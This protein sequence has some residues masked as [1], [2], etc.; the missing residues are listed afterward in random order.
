[1]ARFTRRMTAEA[2]K[3]QIVEVTLGLIAKYGL[4]GVTMSRIADG[5]GIT[6]ASIYTHFENRRAVLLAALDAIYD[7]IYASRATASSENTLERLRE[8]CEHHLELWANQGEEHHAHLF[9][10][11]IAGAAGEG[12]REIMAEKHLATMNQFAQIVED[13]KKEG[14]IPE[15]VDSEQVAWLITGW[16][17]AGD[18]SHL[19]GF[20]GFLDPRISTHWLD[21][22]FGSFV[23]QPRAAESCGT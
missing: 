16:A 11:F 5:A 14:H 21:V 9:L 13:G 1:M 18:V 20:K 17:F 7:K 2:R 22:I 6:Q 3:R 19:M 15:Y 10:E 23:E 4:Q 8:I 12:L